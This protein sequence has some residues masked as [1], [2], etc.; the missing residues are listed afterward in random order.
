MIKPLLVFAGIFAFVG[1]AMPVEIRVPAFTGYLNPD[2][3][4]ARVSKAGGISDWAENGQCVWWFGDFKNTGKLAASIE[5]RLPKG[6]TSKL[7]LT[8]GEQT[9]E[10]TVTGSDDVVTISFGNFTIAKAD[11]V[12]IALTSLNGDGQPAGDLETLVLSGPA[13]EGAHFNL[14]PRRNAASVH[15]M[16]PV[17]PDAK[18]ALFYNEII[19]LEDPVGSYYMACGFSRGYFGMQVNSPSERRIIFSVW[20][21]GSGQDAKDRSTVDAG[22]HVQLVEK[23]DGVVASVFGNEGT[24]GHSH[25]VYPWKTGSVQ[26]FAVSAHPKGADTVY[27]GYWF[28]PKQKHWML[29]ASFRAP[30]DGKWLRGLYSFSENF[31]GANGHLRRKALFGPAWLRLAD[32]AWDEIT[33]ASFSHDGTGKTARLDRFMGIE[34]GRFFL[35]HGGFISGSTPYGERFTRPAT[36]S[37]PTDFP[38]SE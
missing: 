32:G 7:R 10:A 22:N 21:S 19:G 15:L 25:L 11:Y 37:P 14:E 23:G 33:E 35:S 38:R 5:L 13:T 17:P 12:R 27:A 3:D 18:V 20:D 2:P 8:I 31:S 16:Y 26:R 6:R 29:I 30:K 34:K 24:G 28:H 4:G 1:E 36:N 9:R